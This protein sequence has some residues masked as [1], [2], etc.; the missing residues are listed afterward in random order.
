MKLKRSRIIWKNRAKEMQSQIK[1][2]LFR[3]KQSLQQ[4]R[5]AALTTLKKQEKYLTERVQS[6]KEEAQ[7]REDQLRDADQSALL[8]YEEDTTLNTEETKPPSLKTAD[9]PTFSP[10][11]S[12]TKSLEKMLGQ[13]NPPKQTQNPNSTKKSSDSA[14]STKAEATNLQASSEPE[15]RPPLQR[16]VIYDIIKRSL[17]TIPSVLSKFDVGHV[18]PQIACTDQGLAWVKTASNTLQL[19]D[20]A[21]SVKDTVDI[22]FTFYDTSLTPDGDILLPDYDS[23]C[24]KLLSKQKKMS[25]LFNTS[26]SPDGLSCLH[27]NDIVVTFLN[28]NKLIVYCK[29]GNIKQTLDHIKFRCPCKVAVNKINQNIYICDI[30]NPKVNNNGK[31]I[32]VGADGKL[33]Y[34]YSGQGDGEFS[35]RDVC[36]DH[37]G[38]VLIADTDNHRVHILDQDVQ[39]I[40]Y[41]L[42]SQQGLHRPITIDVDREG[43]VWVGEWVDRNKGRV[44][45]AK[46]LQ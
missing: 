23:K 45:V 5:E 27:N 6:L 38:H 29:T 21:G 8:Q 30:E 13:L 40:Q 36:T 18:F 42:T 32:A 37:I 3:N 14:Q 43:C 39:F 44:K 19:V 25:T 15:V 22:D 33:R 17:I 4:M 16:D 20:R 11:Q 10:G 34:E 35:P 12:D 46:Y 28:E 26:W 1:D 9:L 24:I 2:I 41:I 31:L 7:H